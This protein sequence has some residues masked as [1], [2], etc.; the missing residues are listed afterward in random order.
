MHE[1]DYDQII[2]KVEKLSVFT[3]VV[4]NNG[5]YSGVYNIGFHKEG[6]L[7]NYLDELLDELKK[8]S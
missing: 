2:N 4:E 1:A 3:K 8:L 5:N 6:E 7:C